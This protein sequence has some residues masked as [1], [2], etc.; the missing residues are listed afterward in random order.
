MVTAQYNYGNK[1]VTSHLVVVTGG[2]L[3]KRFDNNVPQPAFD[4]SSLGRRGIFRDAGVTSV[5]IQTYLKGRISITSTTMENE[6]LPAYFTW[7]LSLMK[8]F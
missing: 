8:Q 5:Y 1:V 6:I 7:H 2:G 4:G 3:R